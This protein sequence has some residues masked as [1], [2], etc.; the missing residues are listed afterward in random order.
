MLENITKMCK[1]LG[2]TRQCYYYICKK[3][4]RT[5]TKKEVIK[6]RKE[7][8]NGRPRKMKKYEKIGD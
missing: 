2:I 3:M 1:E 4:G 8:P 6:W 5:A 7:H